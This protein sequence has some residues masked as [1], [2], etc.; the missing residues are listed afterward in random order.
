MTSGPKW[1]H[2][3]ERA[4][5]M[6]RRSGFFSELSTALQ[7]LA[8]LGPIVKR[9]DSRSA[10]RWFKTADDEDLFAELFEEGRGIAPASGFFGAH[11]WHHGSYHHIPFRESDPLIKKW[12]TPSRE[13]RGL[14]R[15]L[16]RNAGFTAENTIAI[17]I[18]GGDKR[19]EVPPTPV[20]Q[21]VNMAELLLEREPELK[22]LLASDDSEILDEFLR[23]S[24]FAVSVVNQVA[25]TTTG[26]PMQAVLQE[27]SDRS[28]FSKGF[29]AQTYA[30]ARA[31][32]LITHTGNTAYWSALYWGC[33]WGLF[34]FTRQPGQLA[35]SGSPCSVHTQHRAIGKE[36]PVV[37]ETS[38][39][40][41]V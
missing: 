2:L 8:R 39:R 34:Q 37:A 17:N 19:R 24:T 4:Y 29:L 25:R 35:A 3:S 27:L 11:L 32:Y 9:I 33:G 15:R 31:R 12:F 10:L 16:Y 38:E 14:A 30:I 18:R 23:K 28:S 40:R 13:V 7:D 6:S 21:Y 41:P 22:V 20:N 26:T 1:G 36:R 5:V